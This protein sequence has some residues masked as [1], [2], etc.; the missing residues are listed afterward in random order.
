MI[1]YVK[2]YILKTF[3][4][5]N[6]ELGIGCTNQGIYGDP[7]NTGVGY[8]TAV[9]TSASALSGDRNGLAQK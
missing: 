8:N 9:Y 4:G 7:E 2:T 5:F 1:I 6:A 3:I